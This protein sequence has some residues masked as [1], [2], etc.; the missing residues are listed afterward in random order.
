M[1]LPFRVTR[2]RFEADLWVFILGISGELCF[3]GGC[4]GL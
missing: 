1:I 4:F 3:L 2:K